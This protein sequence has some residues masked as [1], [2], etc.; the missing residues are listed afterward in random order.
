MKNLKKLALLVA[1]TGITTGVTITP[2][3]AFT[4]GNIGAIKPIGPNLMVERVINTSTEPSGT[5]DGSAIIKVGKY[6]II[7]LN[8][9]SLDV[10]FTVNYTYDKVKNEMHFHIEKPSDVE[11]YSKEVTDII[12]DKS[13]NLTLKMDNLPSVVNLNFKK[14]K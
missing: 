11:V 14:V 10:R 2:A 7:N 6:D 1:L 5:I 9:D 3:S 13:I 12:Q 8:K 4:F